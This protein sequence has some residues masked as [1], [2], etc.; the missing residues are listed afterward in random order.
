VDSTNNYAASLL[1]L[2]EV[3]EGTVVMAHHQTNGRGQRGN[4]WSS[5]PGQNLLCSLILRPNFLN[6]ADQFGLNRMVSLALLNYLKHE[7]IEAVIK[8]PN[9][10][11]VN[12]QKIAGI[13]IENVIRGNQLEYTIV[14]IGLN[15][16]QQIFASEWKA[17]SM[18]LETGLQRDLLAELRDLISF[19]E[20]SYA[21]LQFRP[22][23]LATLYLDN[24]YGFQ[25]PFF[26]R[27]G[28]VIYKATIEKI[29]EQGELHLQK[30]DGQRVVKLFK[31]IEL[32]GKNG[33]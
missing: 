28:H 22:E 24:L 18:Q 1:K 8:W 12:E 3:V 4:S 16:N 26:Y 13:L 6:P 14:G 21:D 10:I 33:L 17:T 25:V 23:K 32:L 5:N 2:S 11:L 9:D 29:G 30:E 20:S 15:M 27:D 7:G 31:E 19:I